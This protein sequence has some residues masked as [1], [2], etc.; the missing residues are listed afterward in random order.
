M[1]EISSNELIEAFDNAMNSHIKAIDKLLD[2]LE[3]QSTIEQLKMAKGRMIKGI[4]KLNRTD[5]W[6]I[7]QDYITVTIGALNK[8][9]DNVLMLLDFQIENHT[10]KDKTL[11]SSESNRFK[12]IQPSRFAY[13]LTD[14]QIDYLFIK[15]IND[16]F[17][18]TNSDKQAFDYIF[19]NNGKETDFKQLEWIKSKW[20]LAYFI[21]VLTNKVTNNSVG[22]TSWKW[23]ENAF[24]QTN[25]RGSKSEYQKTGTLPA[26]NKEIDT[27]IVNMINIST[28]NKIS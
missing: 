12:M 10:S 7:N 6:M 5:L 27:I 2:R 8:K 19:G 28:A 4:N 17:L 13:S 24:N 11:D 1:K 3:R 25:L 23:A 22:R 9:Y 20:L 21:D 16:G 26:N 18:S 15:L 14:Y